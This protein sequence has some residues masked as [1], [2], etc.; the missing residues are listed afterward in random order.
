MNNGGFL[1]LLASYAGRCVAIP[2]DGLRRTLPGA[3]DSCLAR[4]RVW[5]HAGVWR[6]RGSAAVVPRR[7]VAI[8]GLGCVWLLDSSGRS[9]KFFHPRRELAPARSSDLSEK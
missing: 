6:S 8:P 9:N 5:C 2:F 4:V 3:P 7:S 1:L